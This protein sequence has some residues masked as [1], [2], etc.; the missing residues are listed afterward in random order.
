MQ[1]LHPGLFLITK[2]FR[3][4]KKCVSTNKNCLTDII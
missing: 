2:D 1:Y 3:E 4:N